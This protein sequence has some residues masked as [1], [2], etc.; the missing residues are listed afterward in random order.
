MGPIVSLR[1]PGLLC[2]HLV[3]AFRQLS[4][5]SGWRLPHAL[6]PD[7]HT[8]VVWIECGMECGFQVRFLTCAGQL[9]LLQCFI[10]PGQQLNDQQIMRRQ[11]EWSGPNGRIPRTSLQSAPGDMDFCSHDGEEPAWRISRLSSSR[12]NGSMSRCD[13]V[14]VQG[15]KA[16]DGNLSRHYRLDAG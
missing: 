8:G 1:L 15:G 10:L 2:R 4:R 13:F 9:M 12:P 3:D 6:S 14:L 7:H 16:R 5:S 11:I